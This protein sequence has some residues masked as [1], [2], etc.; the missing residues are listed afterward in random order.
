MKKLIKSLLP[1]ILL[2]WYRAL[3]ISGI[4]FN[5][6]Y[7]SWKEAKRYTK[8]YNNKDIFKKVSQAAL[9]VKNGEFAFERDSILFSEYEYLWSSLACLMHVAACNKGNLSVLDFGGSLG[10]SYF[11]NKK[12]LENI[13]VEWSVVEQPHFVDYGKKEISDDVLKFYYNISECRVERNPNCVFLSSVIQYLEDPYQW[14][15]IF[16]SLD[17]NF[18]LIDR[19]IFSKKQNEFIQIQEVPSSIYRASYPLHALNEEKITNLMI[20]SGYKLIERFTPDVKIETRRIYTKGLFF[21]K[22]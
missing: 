19:T 16:V 22:V 12:F 17:V 14:L 21:K 10:S 15:D 6:E 11:L 1:P 18:I 4:R 3:G 7:S 9:K 13:D 20:E 8:G 5:G 2:N